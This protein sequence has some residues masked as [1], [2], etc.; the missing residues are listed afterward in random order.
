MSPI[1]VHHGGGILALGIQPILVAAWWAGLPVHGASL[2]AIVQ[3][4]VNVPPSC[5]H[6]PVQ[7]LGLRAVYPKIR[8]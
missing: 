6:E 3:Y 4:F 8:Q 5:G 1:A 2:S 7:I